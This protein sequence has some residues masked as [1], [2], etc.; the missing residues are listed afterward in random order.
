[1]TL[2]RLSLPLALLALV[3]APA[4]TACQTDS[5]GLPVADA[6]AQPA[7]KPIT[8]QEAALQC[9]METEHGHA[10]MPLDK[11]ADIVTAC[12][13]DKM[14]GKKPPFAEDKKKTAKRKPDK[15]KAEPKS[16]KPAT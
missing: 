5:N 16:D 13:T 4:L 9:W 1:M 15:P 10:D 14:E 2:A 11:R 3:C 8:H 7:A 6:P 12:I